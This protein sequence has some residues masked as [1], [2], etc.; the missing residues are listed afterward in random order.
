MGAAS[1]PRI[2]GKLIKADRTFCTVFDSLHK[3]ILQLFLFGRSD[4]NGLRSIAVV[5]LSCTKFF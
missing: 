4:N 2:I 1:D 3:H 5:G